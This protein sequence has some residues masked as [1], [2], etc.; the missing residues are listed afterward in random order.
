MIRESDEECLLLIAEIRS[1]GLNVRKATSQLE[2]LLGNL[3]ARI[4]VNSESE[5]SVNLSSTE[6]REQL[7]DQNASSNRT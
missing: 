2:R 7:I 5:E 1:N 3:E 4:E 6:L